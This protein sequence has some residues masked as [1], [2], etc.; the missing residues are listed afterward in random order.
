MELGVV[1]RDAFFFS[2]F[3]ARLKHSRYA[4][5]KSMA[6]VKQRTRCYRFDSRPLCKS[7]NIYSVPISIYLMIDLVCTSATAAV[8]HTADN[9]FLRR[10]A[11]VA[12]GPAITRYS[13]REC[14]RWHSEY[15][16]HR[17]LS[18]VLLSTLPNSRKRR[19]AYV[20]T[21]HPKIYL[22]NSGVDGMEW[23]GCMNPKCVCLIYIKKDC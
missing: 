7:G 13:L 2:S 12:P 23:C 19:L 10:R 9:S 16:K 14:V 11:S 21:K 22:V 5:E 6:L 15:S 4:N 18:P 17:F 1:P 8:G 3:F 20:T